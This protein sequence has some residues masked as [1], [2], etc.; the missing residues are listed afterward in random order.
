MSALVGSDDISYEE[1]VLRNPFSLKHWWWYLEFKTKAPARVG[2]PRGRGG[3]HALQQVGALLTHP[4]PGPSRP[5]VRY[6][7]YERAVKR[8][9]RSYKLWYRYLTERVRDLRDASPEDAGFEQTN[10]AFE[11]SLVTMH[12]MPRVWLEY[13]SFLIAQKRI[14]RTRRTFDRALRSLPVTQHGRVWPLYL[15][16]V[17][18]AK[19]PEL[20]VRVYRRYLKIEPDRI[21]EFVDYLKKIRSWD[22]ASVQLSKLVN[23]ESFVSQFGRSRFDMWKDLLSIITR[24][25]GAIRSLDVDAVIRSGIRRFPHQVG[26]LWC[27]LA[28]YYVTDGQFVQARNVYEEA[29]NTVNTVRDFTVIFD[30]YSQY[31]ESMLNARMETAEEEEEAG[32]SD[33]GSTTALSASD[34]IDWRMMRLES[35]MDRRALLLNSVLLRQNPHNVDEWHRRVALFK[36]DPIKA[37]TTYSKAVNT[38][39]PIKA[40]GKPH[41][42]WVAFAGFY[43]KHGNMK[44]ARAIYGKAVQVGFKGVDDL[45]TVWCAWAEM[46]L[47][48]GNRG[49]AL[50]V[51]RRACIVPAG[52]AAKA[53]R[54]DGVPVQDRLWRST[55]L[56]SLYADLEENLGSL[57]GVRAIYESMLDLKVATPQIVLNYAALLEQNKFFEQ[58]F[59]AY[60]KGVDLFGFPHVFPIWVAYLRRFIQRYGGKKKERARD[61]FQQAVAKAGKKHARRLYLLYAKYEE[62][63]GL[64]R[65]AMDVYAKACDAVADEER[66][67]MYGIYISRVTDL[68]GVAKSREVYHEAIRKVPKGN[69][70]PMCLQYASVER[71]LGEIDRARAIYQYASQYCDPVKDA[72]FWDAWKEFE[73]QHGNR[74]TVTDMVRIQ[75]S[76]KG[77]FA[78]AQLLPDIA[79]AAAKGDA[80]SKAR[81]SRPSRPAPVDNMQIVE[82]QA[83][84]A[85]A[86]DGAAPVSAAAGGASGAN[87]EEIDIDD[88]DI[89]IQ[90]IS[91]PETVFGGVGGGAEKSM[92]AKERFARQKQG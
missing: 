83:R 9:P 6:M 77:Q 50:A 46:E 40:D 66:A 15:K 11:R 78:T 37:I 18:A 47:R 43:E 1:N 60:E 67:A 88:D 69:I 23:N 71:R 45:A 39:D 55:K 73:V 24:N 74:D 76:V 31:E 19:I 80:K 28:E 58:A 48:H 26:H 29:L 32:G 49:E 5:Q 92:G 44:N 85:K 68:F 17:R 12:K 10:A 72:D 59:R 38:V 3:P 61:L 89:D 70:K 4:A 7:L 2:A 87:P 52:G 42:L 27:A 82:E 63:F 57:D 54:G 20:A 35:L 64:A 56:W 41:S 22:E 8:L 91:V 53:P 79:A 62:D 81:P 25:P 13:L 36:D 21:E 75:R 16:F 90:E 51:V 84:A 30:A 14:T 34:E 33:R 86:A 65:R